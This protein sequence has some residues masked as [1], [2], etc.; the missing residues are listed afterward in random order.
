M[1]SIAVCPTKCWM[2]FIY[3]L[4]VCFRWLLVVWCMECKEAH[5][6]DGL[7]TFIFEFECQ[8]ND[9]LG[10]PLL[11]SALSIERMVK[12]SNR[13]LNNFGYKLLFTHF[14]CVRSFFLFL[15]I[16]GNFI[17]TNLIFLMSERVCIHKCDIRQY[18]NVG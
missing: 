10:F 2:K 11:A 6:C 3:V 9:G 16:F 1:C 18:V 13:M 12:I 14:S 5:Q 7:H 15:F 8:I 4:L 17:R